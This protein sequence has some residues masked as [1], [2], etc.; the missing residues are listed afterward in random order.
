M[1]KI[2]CQINCTNITS[3]IN[4]WLINVKIKN[5]SITS[6][7][8]IATFQDNV[9]LQMQFRSKNKIKIYLYFPCT[10]TMHF[11]VNV[12]SSKCTCTMYFIVNVILSNQIVLV[13]HLQGPCYLLSVDGHKSKLQ[14][15]IRYIPSTRDQE[16]HESAENPQWHLI[17]WSS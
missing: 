6:R 4:M 1:K 5:I 7:W 13:R 8:L 17:G 14:G 9:L 16:T 11:I 10:C 12:I 2:F 3:K 15:E